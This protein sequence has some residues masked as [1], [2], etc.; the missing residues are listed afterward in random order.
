MNYGD[1]AINQAEI[2]FIQDS[3]PS[4]EIV[5]IPERL[6]S[7]M[8]PVVLRYAT[9]N[10]VIAFHGGGNMGDIWPEQ[11]KLRR[12]VFRS[13]KNFK[14]ISFPQS[15]SYKSDSHSNNLKKQFK[16]YVK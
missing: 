4:S 3:L 10:D 12:K 2:A 8:I 15:L 11:E 1:I 7:A 6:V 16:L 14:V 9:S 5:E 13:F